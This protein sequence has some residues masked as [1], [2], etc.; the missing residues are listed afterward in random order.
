MLP[1]EWGDPLLPFK[2]CRNDRPAVQERMVATA[3]NSHAIVRQGNKHGFRDPIRQVARADDKVDLSAFQHGAQFVDKADAQLDL[4][5]GPR[6]DEG[7]DPAAQKLAGYDGRC[8]NS[9]I[10]GQTGRDQLG[11]GAGL[12]FGDPDRQPALGQSQAEIGRYR[13]TGAAIEDRGADPVF[14]RPDVAAERR[15]AQSDS[16]GGGLKGPGLDDHRQLGEMTWIDIHT[17]L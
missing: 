7:R 2:I 11:I 17:K 15:L 9:Q 14:Q 16:V 12:F 1:R 10:A 8:A 6:A 13:A 5:V 3:Q 4:A